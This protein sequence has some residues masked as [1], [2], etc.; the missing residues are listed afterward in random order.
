M[1]GFCGLFLS[2][3][4]QALSCNQPVFL[5]YFQLHLQL[6][7]FLCILGKLLRQQHRHILRFPR[8]MSGSD[9]SRNV[10]LHNMLQQIIMALHF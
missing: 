5:Q 6:K 2:N 9:Q 1:S 3:W 10:L 8:L 4:L 7:L